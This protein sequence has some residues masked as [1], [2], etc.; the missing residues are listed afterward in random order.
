M[1]EYRMPET[2]ATPRD[3]ADET[4]SDLPGHFSFE[5]NPA[6]PAYWEDVDGNRFEHI[7]DPGPWLNVMQS[8]VLG[9]I[10]TGG[11]VYLILAAVFE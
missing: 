11:I 6:A 8:M 5:D 10:L 2:Y 3:L 7:V 9:M 4:I 1:P